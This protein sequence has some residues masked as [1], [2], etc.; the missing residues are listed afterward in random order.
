MPFRA[1]KASTPI[2]V[3]LVTIALLLC[4]GCVSGGEGSSDASPGPG[5]VLDWPTLSVD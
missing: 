1:P 4:S 2:L 3:G 5:H